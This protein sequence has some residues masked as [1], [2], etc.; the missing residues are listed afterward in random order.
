MLDITS[1]ANYDEKKEKKR[2]S[3]RG[4]SWKHSLLQQHPCQLQVSLES[5]VR[6]LRTDAHVSTM[7]E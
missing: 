6:L 5:Y 1:K 4:P 7:D 2:A 3:W